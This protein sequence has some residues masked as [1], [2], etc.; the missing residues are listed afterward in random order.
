MKS[1]N[2]KIGGAAGEGIK[3]SGLILARSLARLGYSVFGYSEYPSLI[4]GGHNTYQIYAGVDEVFSQVKKVDILI[5]LNQETI[6]LHQEE[7]TKDSITLYDP[8][9][10]ELPEGKLIGKYVAVAFGKLAESAGGKAIMAN[11][12]SLAAT[13]AILGLPIDTLKKA[14][15]KIF[16][17]KPKE[18][19]DLNHKCAEAGEK[20]IKENCQEFIKKADLPKKKKASILI[21]GNEAIALGA[22]AGGMR[23][24]ASYPMTPATS[25]IHYLAGVAKKTGIFVKHTEDEISG[26]NMAIGAS[27]AGARAMA[28]T[29]GGGLCLMAEGLGLAGISETPLVIVN[30]MRPGPGAGL[31][32]WSGQGDLKFVLTIGNDE[33]PRI[34]LAPGD[35]DEAFTLTK[36]AMELAEKYQTP[37]IILADKNLSEGDFCLPPYS[38]EH[39]NKRYGFAAKLNND[40][41]GY[42]KRY[43]ITKNGV[44]LRPKLGQPGGAHVCNSYEH[45]EFG[46]ATES[47]EMRKKM[48]DKRQRKMKLIES[49]IPVQPIFG[50][51]KARIGLIS[52]GSNK[53]PILEAMKELDDVKFMHLNW[54]W[55]FPARQVKEFTD[56]VKRIVCLEC[57]AT[58]QLAGLIKEQVGIEVE[59]VLKYDGRGFWPGEILERVR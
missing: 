45:D 59:R 13:M 47:A 35:A 50:D 39:I 52:W 26:I 30:S 44:S 12:V 6:I 17:R 3:S 1:F 15:A 53:G 43:E 25:I 54:L 16:A 34:V 49:E 57:N 27:H 18:I 41:E 42:F 48:A 37:V 38:A 31:P 4:R 8:G 55:P 29:S 24:F 5:A 19:T 10:F 33:F 11:M 22:I 56:S 2:I 20:F 36:R 51:K 40:P 32:T 58:G 23:F 14:I 28:A 46:F 21:T 7:L 9:E